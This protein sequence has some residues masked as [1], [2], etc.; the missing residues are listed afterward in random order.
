V[1]AGWKDNPFIPL[2]GARFCA[3]LSA[4][5]LPADAGSYPTLR[6]V[7]RRLALP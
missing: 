4:L 6:D 5:D 1:L 7:C 3:L 2:T